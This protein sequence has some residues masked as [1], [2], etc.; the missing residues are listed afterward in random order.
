MNASQRLILLEVGIAEA[1]LLI[2]LWFLNEYAASLLSWIIPALCTGILVI[3]LIVEWV[4][5]SSVPRWYYWLMVVTGMIPL[6]VFVFFFILQK[7]H[8][9]WMQRPF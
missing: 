1:I 9:E 8:L 6:L 5:R 3:S 2:A 7:G 4:E